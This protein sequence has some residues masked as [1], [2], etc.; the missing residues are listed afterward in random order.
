VV[1][2]W[3]VEGGRMGRGPSTNRQLWWD[4]LDMYWQLVYQLD[5]GVNGAWCEWRDVKKMIKRDLRDRM[6]YRPGKD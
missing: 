6:R 4:M 2:E 3:T 5:D 1:S